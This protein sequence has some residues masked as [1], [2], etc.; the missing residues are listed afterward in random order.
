MS[1]ARGDGGARTATG[2]SAGPV[3]DADGNVLSSTNARGN[4]TTFDYTCTN[5]I[6]LTTSRTRCCR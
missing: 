6:C 3:F 1:P 4:Q 2:L 5:A